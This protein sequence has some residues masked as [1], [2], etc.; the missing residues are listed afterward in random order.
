MSET[1]DAP[2][3]GVAGALHDLPDQSRALVR[4]Q[5]RG[6]QQEMWDKYWQSGPAPAL[7]A[8]AVP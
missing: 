5:I 3:D 7:L 4:R 6:G 2:R 8:G 1:S